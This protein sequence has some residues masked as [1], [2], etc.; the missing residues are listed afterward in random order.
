[1]AAVLLSPFRFD[2]S[3]FV[4]MNLKDYQNLSLF[5]INPVTFHSE[6]VYIHS[7]YI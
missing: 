2:L 4:T 6:N 5:C 7:I 3:T 1:M